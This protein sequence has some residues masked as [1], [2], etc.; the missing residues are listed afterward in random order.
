M[1]SERHFCIWWKY[2]F[3]S[4]IVDVCTETT[5]FYLGLWCIVDTYM[6]TAYAQKSC[7]IHE[8]YLKARI[9]NW[10]IHLTYMCCL[11][12]YVVLILKQQSY[13]LVFWGILIFCSFRWLRIVSCCI[14]CQ[15]QTTWQFNIHN[16]DTPGLPLWLSTK[17]CTM[18]A[19]VWHVSRG[20][21][22]PHQSPTSSL[23]CL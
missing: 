14:Q 12:S 21:K 23:T 18:I 10:T 7:G 11:S 1:Q 17:C 5:S 19:T 20:S 13:Y 3:A 4:F 2:C 15:W 9:T 16:L 8:S 22:C 6:D